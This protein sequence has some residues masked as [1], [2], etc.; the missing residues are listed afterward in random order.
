MGK[1]SILPTR[2]SKPD[3]F[4]PRDQGVFVAVRDSEA[5]AISSA[6]ARTREDVE[7]RLKA[8]LLYC[9]Q[10]EGWMGRSEGVAKSCLRDALVALAEVW[11]GKSGE[12]AIRLV[13][14]FIA[15]QVDRNCA[16]GRQM[17]G[18]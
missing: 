2:R 8:A 10:A 11:L 4:P 18:A 16:A 1:R 17:E 13:R 14:R 3:T 7:G 15:E 6:Q 12:E 9:D 5:Q